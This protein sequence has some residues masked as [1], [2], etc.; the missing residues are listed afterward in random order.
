VLPLVAACGAT[1]GTGDGGGQPAAGDLQPLS[2]ATGW[3][4]GLIEDFDEQPYALVEIAF[5]Q[6]TAERAWEQNVPD[7][8]AQRSGAPEEDG[9]YGALEG[10]NFDTHAVL[11]WSA[12]QSGSCPGW[13]AGIDTDDAGVV[14]VTTGVRGDV[15]TDDYNA[16]RMVV[17]VERDRLPDPAWL[18]V[19]DVLIDGQAL[20]ASSLVDAYPAGE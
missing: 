6:E 20:A 10:V 12:G 9:H 19:T 1:D 7:G 3:R 5:D 18:P 17:A 11:V 16:Y 13:L 4:D 8:L 15:C 14:E 2:K